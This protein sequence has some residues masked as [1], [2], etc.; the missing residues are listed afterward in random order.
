MPAR[1]SNTCLDGVLAD[2]ALLLG[3]RGERRPRRRPSATGRRGRIL[4]DLLQAR[5]HAGLAEIFLRQHVGGDLRPEL[6][7]LDIVEPGTPPSRPDCGSRSWSA[8]TRCPR[9]ATGRPWCSAAQFAYVSSPKLPDGW[10]PPFCLRRTCPSIRRRCSNSFD[11]T[12]PSSRPDALE[13]APVR[14]GVFAPGTQQ[15]P[16]PKRHVLAWVELID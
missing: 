1:R 9:R 10:P 8:G 3:Q 16:V 12:H 11:A 6:G 7:H 2:V 5:G 4:L 14:S 15:V 13:P